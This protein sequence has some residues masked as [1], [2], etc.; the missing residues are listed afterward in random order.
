VELPPL[1]ERENLTLLACIAS[2][3][4]VRADV[5]AATRLV[6]ELEEDPHRLIRLSETATETLAVLR[7][8]ADTSL[9]A[10]A[11]R[12]SRETKAVEATLENLTETHL[13][14]EVAADEP[15]RHF[16]L[17]EMARR[18]SPMVYTSRIA[19]PIPRE[20]AVSGRSQN[21]ATQA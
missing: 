15:E 21:L 19:T 18:V 2:H 9:A 16:R 8:G 5:P 13:V 12:L 17:R 10:V 4:R 20:L 6:R 7:T 14:E 1:D 11:T 3:D